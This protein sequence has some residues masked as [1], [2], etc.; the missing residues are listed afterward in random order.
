MIKNCASSF[1]SD[2]LRG[3]AGKSL[4]RP[5]S[6][7]RRTESILSMERGVFSCVELQVFSRYRGW[8]EACQATF[9]ISTTSRRELS[10]SFFPPP[11]RQVP[12]G[13]SCHS[14]RNIKGTCTIVCHCKKTGWPSLNVVI[15]TPVLRLVLDDPKQW[16]SRRLLIKLTS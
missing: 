12:E 9:A 3:G 7:F 11:E 10:S 15:F 5:T 14:G 6:R 16:P 8:K 1:F 2:I 13:N 4:A